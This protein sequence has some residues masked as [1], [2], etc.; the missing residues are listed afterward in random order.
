MKKILHLMGCLA[1]SGTIITSYA[2]SQEQ[3]T[4]VPR[5]IQSTGTKSPTPQRVTDPMVSDRLAKDLSTRNTATASQTINWY[6]TS[7][8]YTGNYAIGSANYMARYDQQGNYVETLRRTEW[9][10]TNVP[11]ALLNAYGQSPYKDQ[12]V[13]GYWSVTDA[14]KSGYYLELRDKNGVSSNVW[15]DSQGKFTTLPYSST[16]ARPGNIPKD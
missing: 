8:G 16:T 6:E 15:A 7:Y 1:L 13:T 12:T 5:P 3:T 9:N 14:G 10:N 4:P 2:Q 11:N